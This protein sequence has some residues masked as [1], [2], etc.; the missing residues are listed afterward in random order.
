MTRTGIGTSA[1]VLAVA[2]AIVAAAACSAAVP[3]PEAP[4][5][6]AV[7]RRFREYRLAL[8]DANGHASSFFSR[9]LSD[10]WIGWLLAREDPVDRLDTLETVRNRFRFGDLVH[11]VFR[12]SVTVHG[13]GRELAL[14]CQ[15]KTAAHPVK[16]TV[17]Y[18]MEDG[19]WQIDATAFD[20]RSQNVGS[21][22]P[23]LEEFP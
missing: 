9:H 4:D 5:R 20:S 15:S 18:T 17:T 16:V 10:E 3:A 22:D 13:A 6:E 14:V 8:A 21:K 12:Y 19:Q 23:L 7:Y 1:H 2:L 11:V